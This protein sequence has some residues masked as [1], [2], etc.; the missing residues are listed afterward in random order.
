MGPS[1]LVGGEF[2]QQMAC[3]SNNPVLKHL[4]ALLFLCFHKE[5]MPVWRK[6]WWETLL[7]TVHCIYAV[8]I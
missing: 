8:W 5:F 2:M 7:V 6:A 3:H 4:F 1:K